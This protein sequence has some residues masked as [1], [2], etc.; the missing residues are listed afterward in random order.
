MNSIRK[1]QSRTSKITK[2]AH[3]IKRNDWWPGI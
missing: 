1:L 3:L 2:D